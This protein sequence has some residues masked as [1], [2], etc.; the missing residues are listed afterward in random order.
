MR[1]KNSTVVITGADSGIGRATA[2]RFAKKGARV[3][4][5]SRDAAALETL[6]ADCRRR[7]AKALAVQ[8]DVA[9]P[10]A[11][12]E[13]CESAVGNFGRIDIWVNNAGTGV[14]GPFLDTP[15]EDIQRVVDVDL[16]GVVHGAR[17]ALEQMRAQ[18]E[19]VLINVASMA[20]IIPQPYTSAYSMSKAAVRALGVS[21]RSELRLARV[22]DIH[23][24]TVSPGAV[25]TPFFDHVANYT[26]QDT[27]PIPPTYSPDKI[28]AAIVNVA[29]SPQ[30]E[31][32]VGL[33]PKA[34][35]AKHKLF[36]QAVERR[37]A[38]LTHRKHLKATQPAP[39]TKGNLDRAA[40]DDATGRR[41][42]KTGG[43]GGRTKTMAR[44][45]LVIGG[46]A[47]VT[48][49]AAFRWRQ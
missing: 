46:A 6:A 12:E 39:P 13:L 18:G 1:I 14:F 44:R 26:G 49:F 41:G 34:M 4:L 31:L 5:A 9:D 37:M 19:G 15:L 40:G 28:A 30:R 11:V 3:V 8:T 43:H 42:R 47:G 32:T 20:G 48:A 35:V 29:R 2:L 21:L 17:E 36:P 45:L 38:T 24:V 7:G 33:I 10:E 22:K 27:R 16:M 23:V 25:D